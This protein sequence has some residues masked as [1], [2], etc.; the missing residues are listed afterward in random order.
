M[1]I[2]VFIKSSTF[3]KSYGGL[4]TQ[5]KLLCEGLASR[6]HTVV[7]FTPNIE[8]EAR[9]VRES[10]VL[11]KFVECKVA[12]YSSV[13]VP[14][15]DS[16]PLKS[17]E[18][19]RIANSKEKFDLI[20]G[21]SSA[22]IGVIKSRVEFGVPI[23]SISH[24]TK[25]GEMQT[26][27]QSDVSLK[28]IAR[29]LLDLPHA[30]K[31]F[32][33][34]QREFVHGSNLV[35]A[36]SSYVKKALIDETFVDEQKVRVVNNGIQPF[37]DVNKEYSAEKGN[38][39][40]LYV[41]QLIKSKGILR[42]ADM[43]A[44]GMLEGMSLDIVGAG[45]LYESLDHL[46]KNSGGKI[47]MHGKLPYEDVLKIYDPRRFD[48]FV[49]PTSRI[50][51]FPMVLIEAMFGGLPIVAFGLGGVPDAVFDNETGFLVKA[52][53]FRAF[54]AN[55]EELRNHPELVKKM[56]ANARNKAVE[57]FSLD[58]MLDSYEEIFEEVMK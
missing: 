57:R 40:L 20:I 32:F 55:L 51:G 44:H 4:E 46:A 42:I 52:G 33:T 38:L 24:G 10:G 39:R 21:Q 49:F 12:S 48:V 16:W 28:G 43:V 13:T 30:L 8:L 19:F 58:K 22:A 54:K 14:K 1:R 34:V 15:K 47:N 29:T 11:Y 53:D 5:N 6:G 25:M 56:G 50:E 26:K 31:N 7:V 35:I 23:I 3:S 37:G 18:E 9:E 2:A 41:G 17:L 36:V 45:D 27:I